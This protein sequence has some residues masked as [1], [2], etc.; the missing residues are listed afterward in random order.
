MTAAEATQD[1]Q[2][3]AADELLAGTA[4]VAKISPL[5]SAAH[6]TLEAEQLRWLLLTLHI[7]PCGGLLPSAR[8]LMLDL[9]AVE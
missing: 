1:T 5:V 8:L 7:P 4:K 6:Q 2:K 3:R 9:S